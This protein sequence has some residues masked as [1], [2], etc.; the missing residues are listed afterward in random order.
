MSTS[1]SQSRLNQ[2]KA[3]PHQLIAQFHLLCVTFNLSTSWHS[4]SSWRWQKPPSPSRTRVAVSV[5]AT[6][7]RSGGSH[8]W[9]SGVILCHMTKRNRDARRTQVN[10]GALRSLDQRMTCDYFLFNLDHLSTGKTPQ[11]V[12]AVLCQSQ[13]IPGGIFRQHT[14]KCGV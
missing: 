13:G 11:S 2:P 8:V 10:V 1:S 4:A 12:A 14:M 3:G 5:S 9:P 6:V 7:S